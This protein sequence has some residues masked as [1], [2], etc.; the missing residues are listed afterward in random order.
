LEI[1]H[2]TKAFH[3]IVAIYFVDVLTLLLMKRP[4]LA[5]RMD[6]TCDPPELD[7]RP[8]VRLFGLYLRDCVYTPTEIV[9]VVLGLISI[10][11]WLVAL[12]PQL[13]DNF[14]SKSVEGLSFS[15]LLMWLVGDSA[16]L[17]G[18]IL[19]TQTPVQFYT[20]AYFL[21]MDVAVLAQWGYYATIYPRL[22]GAGSS[23]RRCTDSDILLSPAAEAASYTKTR[24]AKSN[25][26]H[27]HSHSGGDVAAGGIA[28][29]TA[30][31]PGPY[32]QHT[33]SSN[34]TVTTVLLTAVC[35]AWLPLAHS[36][37]TSSEQSLPLCNALPEL[38]GPAKVAGSVLAWISSLCYLFA[39]LPQCLLNYRRKSVEGMSLFI[40]I[41]SICANTTYGFSVIFRIP[42]V[43]AKFYTSTLPYII[44]SLGT[45]IFDFIIIYQSNIY[46][47]EPAYQPIAP[48]F[49]EIDDSEL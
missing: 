16:N 19:T 21:L 26:R 8:Y 2:F 31:P 38:S 15:F 40:F 1:N 37:P 30:F 17:L 20:A 27:Q 7:G 11:F 25:H 46:G 6:C 43:D 39:R 36:A 4:Q 49:A 28:R 18:C 3:L 48:S 5:R 32:T 12:L 29:H 22:F 24:P 47:K 35:L 9:S 10:G 23:G 34:G 13:W 45:L 42:E 14:K 44:G 41:A 33:S